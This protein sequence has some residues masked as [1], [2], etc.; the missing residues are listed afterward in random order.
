[1]IIWDKNATK[2]TNAASKDKLV[3]ASYCALIIFPTSTALT[4]H[5][6]SIVA[7]TPL[8]TKIGRQFQTNGVIEFGSL[9]F[10]KKIF[11]MK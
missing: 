6:L 5:V 2:A 4:T 9:I 11:S 7:T 1:M 10:F 8:A 3:A